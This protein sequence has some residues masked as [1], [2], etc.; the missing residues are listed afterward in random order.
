MKDIRPTTQR[1]SGLPFRQP[2]E[3][4]VKIYPGSE[5]L[6]WQSGQRMRENPQLGLPQSR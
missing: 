5:G 3:A 2:E 6:A 4:G 1:P